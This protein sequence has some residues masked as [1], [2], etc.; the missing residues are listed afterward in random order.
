MGRKANFDVKVKKGPG[1]KARKQPE[2][3]MKLFEAKNLA[4][5]RAEMPADSTPN[6]RQ[7]NGLK[8]FVYILY[9]IFKSLLFST[10]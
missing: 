2:P 5:K 8:R 6:T 4:P 1:R 10:F 3:T 9:L 7:N